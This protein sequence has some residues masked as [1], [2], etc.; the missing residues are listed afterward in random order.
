MARSNP[1]K[2]KKDKNKGKERER[3]PQK[4]VEPVAVPRTLTVPPASAHPPPPPPPT[5]T[6][7]GSR[8]YPE[9]AQTDSQSVSDV[10]GRSSSSVPAGHDS[11]APSVSQDRAYTL[12]YTEAEA[13]ARRKKLRRLLKTMA[14]DTKTRRCVYAHIL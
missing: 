6:S 11:N 4:Q 2:K 7:S 5:A 1:D 13:R 8:D 14:Y 10:E 3:P 9:N 12:P